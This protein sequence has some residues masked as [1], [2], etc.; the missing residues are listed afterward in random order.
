MLIRRARGLLPG[1]VTLAATASFALLLSLLSGIPA[2]KA[3]GSYV[4]IFPKSALTAAGK[5]SIYPIYGT[6]VNGTSQT[7][8]QVMNPSIAE[9]DVSSNE[10]PISG[11]NPDLLVTEHQFSGYGRPTL[12]SPYWSASPT[13][14]PAMR[15]SWTVTSS[16]RS[17]TGQTGPG[18]TRIPASAHL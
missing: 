6:L 9:C 5:D 2:A 1:G 10:P 7:F 17:T 15:H 13:P 12:A 8:Y 4:W 3:T 16:T 18:L 11:T 14:T